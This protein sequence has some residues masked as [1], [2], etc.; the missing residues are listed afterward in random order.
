MKIDPPRFQGC[1]EGCPPHL[2]ANRAVG[3]S[4]DTV[5]DTL[6]ICKGARLDHENWARHYV[7]G[8]PGTVTF[9]LTYVLEYRYIQWIGKQKVA[10]GTRASAPRVP[11]NTTHS[12]QPRQPDYMDIISSAP[13]LLA[14]YLGNYGLCLQAISW[15]ERCIP[16]RWESGHSKTQRQDSIF[17]AETC[18]MSNYP[19]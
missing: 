14:T 17:R 8:S 19:W 13:S 3:L 10:S 12:S 15:I 6:A 2:V 16:D 11:H 4:L 5:S 18:S 9:L 7:L 1:H